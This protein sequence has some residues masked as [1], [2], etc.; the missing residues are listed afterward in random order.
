MVAKG[1][2]AIQ[3]P[4]RAIFQIPVR[5]VHLLSFRPLGRPVRWRVAAVLNVAPDLKEPNSNSPKPK[6]TRMPG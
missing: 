1:E 6:I 5:S 3:W 2:M 4:S